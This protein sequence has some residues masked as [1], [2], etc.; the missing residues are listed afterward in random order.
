MKLTVIGASAGVGL[1]V[2]QLALS[3]GHQVT[4]LSRSTG[5]FPSH[6]NLHVVQGSSTSQLDV[7]EALEGADVALVTLGTGMDTKPTTLYSSSAKTL[8]QAMKS[9]N[10][11]I[12][13]IALTGFGAGDSWGYNS[14]IMKMMFQLFLKQVYADKTLMEHLISESLDNWILVR[15]GR[16]TNG[17]GKGDYKVLAEL[18]KGIKVGAISRKD[19]AHF[20]VTQAEAPKY[21][22]QF[23]ALTD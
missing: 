11:D 12:P 5:T 7:S 15:P 19:V 22:R 8:I 9:E 4:T 21:I 13:V 2:V 6:P 10:L 16:L 17:V 1:A 18:H 23:P 14:P 20:L 3:R